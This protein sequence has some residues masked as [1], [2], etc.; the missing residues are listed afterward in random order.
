MISD[1]MKL[2][3]WVTLYQEHLTLKHLNSPYLFR[4]MLRFF[5]CPI[6]STDFFF[7][8]RESEE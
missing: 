8:Y 2:F 4:T 1:P 7:T 5:S 6:G 3:H